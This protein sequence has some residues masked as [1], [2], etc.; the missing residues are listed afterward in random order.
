MLQVT[1][2]L[3]VE[4]YSFFATALVRAPVISISCCLEPPFWFLMYY[5]YVMLVGSLLCHSREKKFH[6]KT[7]RSLPKLMQPKSNSVKH[8][9]IHALKLG[10]DIVQ[11][12]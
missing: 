7:S 4:A 5:E 6:N 8:W 10:P 11:I 12:P 2:D 1:G 9:L 3:L